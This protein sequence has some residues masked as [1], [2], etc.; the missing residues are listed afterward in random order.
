[1][2]KR[3]TIVELIALLFVVLFLYT[4]ISKLMEYTVFAEQ[5]AQSSLLQSVSGFIA[6]ALPATEFIVAI[7]L[8]LPRYRRWG[9][10]ATLALVIVFT[11]YI[12]AILSFSNEIPCSC[13]GVLEQLSWT[14]HII[15]NTALIIL[16]AVAIIFNRRSNA[17]SPV[18]QSSLSY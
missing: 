16:A 11:A 8:F 15:F 14:G 9:L 4:G 6:W 13:G 1:M 17:N 10:Y 7:L 12:I 5:I 3:A 18:I 2:M